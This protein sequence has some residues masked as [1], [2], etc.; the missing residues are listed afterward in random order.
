MLNFESMY[1]RTW[2]GED[3]CPSALRYIINGS[4]SQPLSTIV[5]INDLRQGN[6]LLI[7]RT[8]TSRIPSHTA[9]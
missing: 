3:S 1:L 9:L 7:I 4:L 6:A 2:P 5:D 8:V